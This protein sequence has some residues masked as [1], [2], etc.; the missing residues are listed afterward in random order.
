M[1]TETRFRAQ[2]GLARRRVWKGADDPDIRDG[3]LHARHETDP[4]SPTSY[5]HG[6]N[7]LL[8]G[9]IE[10]ELVEMDD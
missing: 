7:T 3:T 5:L 8:A 10:L 4:A 1:P 6:P 9:P 2:S